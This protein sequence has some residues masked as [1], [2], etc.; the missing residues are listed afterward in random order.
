MTWL[1]WTIS[2][3]FG[4]LLAFLVYRKDKQKQAPFKWLPAVLRFFTGSLT[5]LLLLAPVFSG[6]SHEEEQPTI[7]WLQDISTS[8]KQ[9]LGGFEK[10][11]KEQQEQVLRQLKQQ[12][13]VREFGFGTELFKDSIYTYDQKATNITQ[14]LELISTQFQDKN[15]G[16]I[17]LASD[18]I[19]NQGS[20]PSFLQLAKPVPIYPI[21]LGDS[22]TPKDLRLSSIYANKTVA[23][24]NSFEIFADIVATGLAGKQTT[25]SLI[26]QGQTIAT[27]PISINNNDFAQ[28]L[29][30]TASAK[31]AGLQKYSISIAATEGETNLQNNSQS[32]I[33]EVKERKT[34]I[35][36]LANAPHPDIAV[37]RQAINDASQF[38]L[39][40]SL[41][42]SIPANSN[43]F[44]ILIAYQYIPK[45]KLNLPTWYITGANMATGNIATLKEIE[46][47]AVVTN[48][49]N[50]S[51]QLKDA[52]TQFTLPSGIRAA[53]P[54]MPPLTTTLA[55]IKTSEQTLLSDQSGGA[56]WNYYPGTTPTSILIG[57]GLWRW[58]VYEYKNFNNYNTT[59]ELIRQTLSFLQV[60][61]ENKPFKINVLKNNITDNE[62][63][64]IL[65]ELRNP[66]GELINEPEAK[67]SLSSEG[68]T[69]NY[70]FEKSGNAYR[71]QA[72]LL[73]PGDY[74]LKGT[75]SWKGK[76]Y[77]DF[78][79][80]HVSDIPLEAL[81]THADFQLMYQLAAKTGGS[82]F[83]Q[84]NFGQLT[85]SLKN[86]P[87]IKPVIHSQSKSK[88]IIDERWLFFLI[89]ALASLEWFL[90]KYWNMNT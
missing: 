68:K 11:Y 44:D 4:I 28:S 22:T 63:A 1:Y 23:L 62:P 34:K 64:I 73:A 48:E 36:L 33:V 87:Q 83:T 17:I 82:F 90:R 55:G 45:A 76:N 19:Y 85:D 38:E 84:Y 67:L 8:S 35:L 29:S 26:H 75:V 49:R 39:T 86:N 5:A 71:L 61:K 43:D 88:P 10:K 50:I 12:Y 89:I 52:F 78:G 25:A 14:A 51:A 59:H 21:A 80:L 66:N 40:V 30:F 41:N 72:G 3:I 16:A 20:N 24:N 77:E 27:Q 56:V 46:S 81:R 53:L 58:S 7:I 2:I 74:N 31:Q 9:S 18:G 69:L 6:L 57:E 13:N 65:A 79:L 47:G 32:I 70:N 37:I 42:G 60:D 54:K 15:L